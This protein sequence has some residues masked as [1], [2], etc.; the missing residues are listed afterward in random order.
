M[1]FQA[2]RF[3]GPF[4][5]FLAPVARCSGKFEQC[6]GGEPG[7][8]VPGS[9]PRRVAAEIA[10]QNAS[11]G[12]RYP[13]VALKNK[14]NVRVC[15][16]AGRQEWTPRLPGRECLDRI[17]GHMTYEKAD[18][19]VDEGMAEWVTLE[20]VKRN[21]DVYHVRQNAIR[22]LPRRKWQPRESGEGARRMRVLQ[23]VS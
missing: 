6:R 4:L 10:T 1:K 19:L 13:R 8:G 16:L 2:G 17:H 12:R 9:V 5:C 14:R 18:A 15:V 7:R 20:R 22:L 3:S 11:A 21:G 23:L